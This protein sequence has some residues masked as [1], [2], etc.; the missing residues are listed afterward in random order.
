MGGFI[1]L[2]D[3][4]GN[5]AYNRGALYLGTK[6]RVQGGLYLGVASYFLRALY[7]GRFRRSGVMM[8]PKIYGYGKKKFP[9]WPSA[10]LVP[11]NEGFH[12]LSN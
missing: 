9:W 10:L 11:G 3:C 4:K 7:L 6:P 8:T 2:M 5:M 12:Q 1:I